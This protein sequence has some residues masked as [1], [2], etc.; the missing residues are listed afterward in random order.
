[1]RRGTTAPL[2]IVIGGVDL[3]EATLYVSLKQ[4]STEIYTKDETRGD[5]T[6]VYDSAKDETTISITYTQAQTLSLKAGRA[7][8]QVRWIF[9]NGSADA[10][11]SVELMIQD[12]Q[13][14]GEI[15]YV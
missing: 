5:V 3:T 8:L 12:I 9:D 1:M 6:R 4:G 11:R 13:H 10:T 7:Y 15:V 2:D 14:E